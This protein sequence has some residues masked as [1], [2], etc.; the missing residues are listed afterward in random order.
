M[1]ALQVQPNQS[2]PRAPEVYTAPHEISISCVAC[3]YL[4]TTSTLKQKYNRAK[5][6]TGF[7][8]SWL[9]TRRWKAA[10]IMP[11]TLLLG[12]RMRSRLWAYKLS[13]FH[14]ASFSFSVNLFTMQSVLIT[15]AIHLDPMQIKSK[16]HLSSKQSLFVL[17]DV[18]FD[19][20]IARALNP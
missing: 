13:S 19:L 18:Y 3:R 11:H 4:S 9:R 16:P 10:C 1:R 5:L 12:V 8:S 7:Q 2:S 15:Q 14:L 6:S 20:I 17:Q